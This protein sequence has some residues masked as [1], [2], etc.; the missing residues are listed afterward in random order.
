MGCDSCSADG[1][2]S[3]CKGSLPPGMLERYKLS[4]DRSDGYLVWIEIER[5]GPPRVSDSTK[6]VLSR[7]MEVNDCSRVWGVVFGHTELKALYH[8]IYSY[9][10]ETLY[11]VHGTQYIGY[12]PDVYS[13]AIS[14]IIVRTEPAMVLFGGTEKGSELACRVSCILNAESAT[15]CT[16]VEVNDRNMTVRDAVGEYS[17]G[18]FPQIASVKPGTYRIGEPKKDDRGTVI[19]WQMPPSE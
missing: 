12:D 3:N 15:D 11:A 1:S 2:C 19:Y 10:V 14:Q 4:V 8:E 5:D 17:F 18:S 6:E 16:S 13:L 7:I 9:G